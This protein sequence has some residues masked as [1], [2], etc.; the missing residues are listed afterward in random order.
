MMSW[1]KKAGS[2]LLKATEVLTGIGPLLPPQ[3]QHAQQV[4]VSDLKSIETIIVQVEA[5][6]QVLGIAGPD[7]LKAAAPLVAQMILQSSIVAG[8][9]IDNPA[10]FQQ[11][12]SKIADGMADVLNS[13][14]PDIASDSKT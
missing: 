4:I 10:L 2:I 3:Y 11:G 7:K 14:K 12:A 6:G 13:L 8:R 5:F 1:L 9:K